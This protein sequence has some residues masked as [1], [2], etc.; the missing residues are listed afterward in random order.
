MLVFNLGRFKMTLTFKDVIHI[1]RIFRIAL[2]CALTSL[3]NLADPLVT[4]VLA[5]LRKNQRDE[6]SQSILSP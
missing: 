3:V 5:Y 1:C 4:G 6:W 2:K